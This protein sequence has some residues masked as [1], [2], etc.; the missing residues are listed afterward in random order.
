M[1]IVIPRNI[2]IPTKKEHYFSTQFDNQTSILFPVYEGERARTVD[3]N[4]LGKLKLSSIPATRRGVAK[5][6][7]C[8]EI[9]ANG[10]L[11]L[12]AVANHRR[13]LQNHHHQ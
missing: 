10:I 2:A 6:K 11:N 9:D 8:F 1:F 5:V 12:S 4:L 13:E 3:N 7:V